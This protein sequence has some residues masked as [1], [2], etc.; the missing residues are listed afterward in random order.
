VKIDVEGAEIEVL[1]GLKQTLKRDRPNL[2]VET[3]GSNVDELKAL[4]ENSGYKATPIRLVKN[5][6]H[7]YCTAKN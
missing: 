6:W 5:I 2:I 4:M 3:H 1:Q 7:F